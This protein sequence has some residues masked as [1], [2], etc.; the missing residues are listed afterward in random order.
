METTTIHYPL[1]KKAAIEEKLDFFAKKAKRYKLQPPQIIWLK[2]TF[3]EKLYNANGSHIATV[4]MGTAELTYEPIKA[5]DGWRFA[6]LIERTEAGNLLSGPLSDRLGY[7][8]E[9]QYFK[10]EH[11]YTARNRKQYFVLLDN[12]DRSKMVGSSCLKDFLGHDPAEALLNMQILQ[13]LKE[14]DEEGDWGEAPGATWLAADFLKV[15]ALTMAF[16][17]RFGFRAARQC[18]ELETPTYILINDQLFNHRLAD[19][20]KI[21]PTPEEEGFAEIILQRWLDVSERIRGDL[22]HADEW[23]YRKHLFAVNRLITPQPRQMAVAVGMLAREYKAIANERAGDNQ[24]SNFIGVPNEK[25]DIDVVITHISVEPNGMYGPYEIIK[26]VQAGTGNKW[27]W[28]NKGKMQQFIEGPC[29]IRATVKAHA[30]DTR[31]GKQT[32]LIRVK[33]L[34]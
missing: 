26:G 14:P 8:R 7:L 15:A 3:F 21:Q 29:R 19:E 6:A 16:V 17:R 32:T 4:E 33:R 25:I 34:D 28:F 30:D 31:W 13:W 12:K 18:S 24:E 23:E 22:A 9:Q 1:W 27:V 20:D 2:E 11:C 10:C 5:P